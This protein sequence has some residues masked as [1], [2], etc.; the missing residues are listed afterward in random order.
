MHCTVSVQEEGHSQPVGLHGVT[1]AED[2]STVYAQV[3]A[4]WQAYKLT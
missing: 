4:A 3:R 1:A 2:V